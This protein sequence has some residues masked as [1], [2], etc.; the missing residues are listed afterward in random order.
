MTT[1]ILT[2]TL[3]GFQHHLPPA[4]AGTGRPLGA[5]VF[6]GSFP[7]LTFA[8]GTSSQ[9]WLIR[10]AAFTNSHCHWCSLFMVQQRKGSDVVRVG[11]PYKAIT[12]VTENH[13]P[14]SLGGQTFSLTAIGPSE[15][16]MIG[17]G[18][19]IPIVRVSVEGATPTCFGRAAEY[20]QASVPLL[21]FVE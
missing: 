12:P 5:N 2:I 11:C 21:I 1:R 13:K 14:A 20:G 7:H 10:Q 4:P 3:K 18:G 8:S 9:A 6:C 19:G 15:I 17:A 16:R